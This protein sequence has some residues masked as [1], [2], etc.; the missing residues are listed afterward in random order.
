MTYA[1]S[2]KHRKRWTKG[3]YQVFV[4]YGS[5]LVHGLGRGRQAQGTDA[6]AK[7]AKG[8]FAAYDMFMTIAPAMVLTLVSASV[9]GIYLLIGL[10]FPNVVSNYEVRM[11]LGAFCM[12]FLSFYVTFFL[13][14]VLTT[15]SE[16]KNIHARRS[17]LVANLFTFPVFMLSY[18]PIALAAA[19]KKVDWVPTKHTISKSL[20]D[21]TAE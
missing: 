5:A 20:D 16:R 4:K 19:V 1:A 6:G 7:R 13:L 2:R 12:T 15:V 21:I 14:A 10:L 3:F 8:G 18:V 9:N 11:C 17:H